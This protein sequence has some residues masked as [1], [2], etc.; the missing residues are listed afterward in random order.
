MCNKIFLQDLLRFGSV[1]DLG[2]LWWV[3]SDSSSGRQDCPIRFVLHIDLEQYWW[4]QRNCLQYFLPPRQSTSRPA[5]ETFR[6]RVEWL[7]K[8]GAS[9]IWMNSRYVNNFLY[10]SNLNFTM[11]GASLKKIILWFFSGNDPS[12]HLQKFQPSHFLPIS[13]RFLT[14]IRCRFFSL[15][16][17]VVYDQLEL[18]WCIFG[19]N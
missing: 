19:Q 11:K 17:W 7:S 1:R 5:A 8:R 18:D 13:P 16:I 15:N 6:G 2:L 4:G 14:N 3:Q 12:C 9:N 10:F